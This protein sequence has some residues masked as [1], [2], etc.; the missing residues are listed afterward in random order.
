[1]WAWA[2]LLA[3]ASLA[4]SMPV[5]AADH[6]ALV[7]QDLLVEVAA[8]RSET[9]TW[10]LRGELARAPGVLLPAGTRGITVTSL[11][12]AVEHRVVERADGLY[13]EPTRA[14]VVWTVHARLDAPADD[15][16]PLYARRM[17]V[18]AFPGVAN[19]IDARV[20]IPEGFAFVHTAPAA[21]QDREL[22]ATGAGGFALVYAYRAP[23]DPTSGLVTVAEG[24]YR[25]V[26]PAAAEPRMRELARLATNAS[27]HAAQQAGLDLQG[28]YW[29]R[30]APE[31]AFGWESG[32]YGYDGVIALRR[33]H[34]AN[35][36]SAGWPWAAAEALVH[37][38]FHAVTFPTGAGALERNATW[39]IEGTA[40]FA[41]RF[42]G[43]DDG[44][45][46]CEG[47]WCWTFQSQLDRADLDA[48]YASDWA[49]DPEWSMATLD[50]EAERALR[51]EYS[52]FLVAAYVTR[53]GPE[54]YGAAWADLRDA[55]ADP[56]CGC[57]AAYVRDVLVRASGG[58]LSEDELYA[59]FRDL[60]V[61][62]PARYATA[63]AP[64]VADAPV[65]GAPRPWTLP[66]RAEAPPPPPP[67][68]PGYFPSLAWDEE[69][70]PRRASTGF[71][72]A[73]RVTDLDVNASPTGP[74]PAARLRWLLDGVEA[75]PL[76]HVRAD[77]VVA[78]FRGVHGGEHFVEVE[79]RRPGGAPFRPHLALQRA[80][81]LPESYDLAIVE[82][83]G[84]TLRGGARIV[85]RLA[86]GV[87]GSPY[88]GRGVQ[89][90]ADG[91]PIHANVTDAEGVVGFT[92]PHAA[93]GALRITLALDDT[94]VVAE[95]LYT[96]EPDPTEL[97]PAIVVEATSAQTPAPVWALFAALGLSALAARR[98]R[99]RGGS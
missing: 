99:R 51:Y 16:H 10:T 78:S 11:G 72:V 57:D 3:L 62:D 12:N 18:S 79:V 88:A 45:R 60:R 6:G 38:T 44:W 28:P 39:W 77:R 73:L 47:T 68:P 52:A 17:Q 54:A 84:E 70:P 37:E 41:E 76:L 83:A 2:L 40:R 42:V 92:L 5:A 50:G 25:I 31:R 59:P 96:V 71:T 63:I 49:F 67:I 29:V 85:G 97:A 61:E 24:S 98:G 14:P 13:V 82:P 32:Y 89:L 46:S 48:L 75:E 9:L 64:L 21:S 69:E 94:D 65:A 33:T 95:R 26:G 1:M 56:S 55:A 74:A 93:P 30:F 66:P 91:I 81:T 19:A 87:D 36:S 20:R 58:K 90:L 15:L 53:Y 86:S 4:A 8:D 22:H 7:A 35:D 43:G 23:D 34:L 27:V 80:F